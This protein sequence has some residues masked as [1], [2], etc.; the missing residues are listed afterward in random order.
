MTQKPRILVDECLSKPALVAIN[1]LL[2]FGGIEAEI[3]HQLD[4]YGQGAVDEVWI[5]Q[6]AKD[7]WTIVT[8]D[9]GK[10]SRIKAK[11]PLLCE[12][13][14]VTHI[15]L[16]AGLE[17]RKMAFKATQFVDNIHGIIAAASSHKGC[18]Y[19]LQMAGE[20]SSRLVLIKNPTPDDIAKVQKKLDLEV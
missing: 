12:A 13:Y 4:I 17:K 5:P 3:A 14:G 16:S 9:R 19:S 18:R 2:K 11:L 7:G 1:P 20:A 8:A 15:L 10:H 6:A